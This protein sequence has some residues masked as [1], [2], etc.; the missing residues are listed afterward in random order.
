MWNVYLNENVTMYFADNTSKT[1]ALAA[2][3]LRSDLYMVYTTILF[4]GIMQS[5]NVLQYLFCLFMI[6]KIR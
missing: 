3:V 5:I 4:W 1:K 2:I 6:F